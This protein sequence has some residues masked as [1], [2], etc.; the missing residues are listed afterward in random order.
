[1]HADQRRHTPSFFKPLLWSITHIYNHISRHSPAGSI[2]GHDTSK[3]TMAPA[4]QV[5]LSPAELSYL[6][7]S[8]SQTPP[9]RPDGRTRTQFR[10]LIAETDVLP[11]TNGSARI[12][13]ADGSEAIVGVKAATERSSRGGGSANT[14]EADGALVDDEGEGEGDD[15]VKIAVEIP[16]YQADDTLPVFLAVMLTEALLADGT[17]KK[18]LRINSRFHWMLYLDV[19]ADSLSRESTNRSRSSCYHRRSH[20]PSPSSP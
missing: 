20:I 11:T 16:G 2:T 19:R 9:I 5:S 18:R 17:L 6:Y 15:W 8:L 12:C 1:M 13:F 10:Q 4:A 7:T 3:P 14:D